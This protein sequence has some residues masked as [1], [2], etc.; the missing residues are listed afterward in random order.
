MTAVKAMLFDLDGTLVDS[1]PDLVA[2]LNYVRAGL[3][4]KPLPVDV[5]SHGV[6]RGAPGLLKAGMPE[7]DEK[8]FERWRKQLLDHYANSGFSLS[9]FYEGI[10]EL[11]ELL[12]SRGL[13]WGIVTNKAEWLTHDFI[14]VKG[15]EGRMSAVVC[16]DTLSTSKPH[17]APVLHACKQMGV[18]PSDTVFAGDDQRDI[19]AGHAAGTRTAAVYYGYGSSGL[20]GPLAEKSVSIRQPSDFF[21]LLK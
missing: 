4:L 3:G 2:A 7:T 12:E 15:L 20:G 10:E 17:P 21:K 18:A 8:T 13:P 6:S 14:K 11:L 19:E 5:A 9:R 1:A 16:G